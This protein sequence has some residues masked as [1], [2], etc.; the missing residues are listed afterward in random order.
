MDK[1][2]LILK[3]ID[4]EIALCQ[5]YTSYWQTM[6]VTGAAKNRKLFHGVDGPEFTA[7][8]KVIDAMDI[9]STHLGNMSRLID[10]KKRLL[11]RN[12]EEEK[13]IAGILAKAKM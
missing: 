7:K 13:R 11:I 10:E 5:A 12:E 3:A 6:A 2:K 9:A 4:Q 1:T 8:E